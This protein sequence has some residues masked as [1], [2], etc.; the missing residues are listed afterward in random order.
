M[1]WQFSSFAPKKSAFAR[2]RRG[3]YQIAMLGLAVLMG[4][5]A[6]ALHAQ[7]QEPLSI[8]ANYFVTGDYV[9]GGVGLQ[10][11]GDSTGY[12]TGYIHIPDSTVSP[13]TGGVQPNEQHPIP[14][15]ADIVAAF[16]YWETVESP[17]FPNAGQ[18]GWF[19]GF[20]ISGTSLV[21]ASNAPVSWS[22]GG[23][24]GSA[25]GSKYVTSYRADVRP[26]LN[27]DPST[28]R[29]LGNS[30]L[31]G[32]YSVKLRDSGSNGGGIPLTLGATLV[33]IYRVL[34]PNVPL[35]SIVI[36]DGDYAP[37]NQASTMTQQIEGFYDATGGSV[38]EL[39]HIVGNGQPKKLETVE[40]NGSPQQTQSLY[41]ALPPF[42]GFYNDSW[43]NPTWTGLNV[44]NGDSVETASVTPTGTN[45]GCEVWGAVI[46]GTTVQDS[47]NDGLL[48]AWKQAKGYT[49]V[50]TGRQVLLPG[51]TSGEKDVF[52]DLDYLTNLSKPLAGAYIHS[53]LPKQA[54]IDE[55]GQ[56]FANAGVHI[57]FD[58]GNVYQ[59]V[60]PDPYI[61]TDGS[62]NAITESSLICQDSPNALCQFPNQV[63][64]GWKAGL[65]YVEDAAV[66]PN[67][68]PTV[69]YFDQAKKDSYHYVLFGHAL[70]LPL[71]WWTTFGATTNDSTVA[72][73]TSIVV[74]ANTATVT[75]QT[76]ANCAGS[77]PSTSGPCYVY[78]GE[79]I[80]PDNP[81]YGDTNL[82]RITVV[83]A[84]NFPALN[85]V[86]KFSN[87]NSSTSNKST[88]T[89]FTI[90]TSGVANGTYT[91]ANE[92]RLA[93]LFAGPSS[94]S[95][96]SD[97]GGGD[98]LITFGLWPAD[99]APGCQPIPSMALAAGQSYCDNEV[100]NIQA[101][102][103]TLMHEL[104]HSFTLTHGGTYYPPGYPLTSIAIDGQNCKPNYESIMN[105]LFQV[106]GFP[107]GSPI[108]YSRQTLPDLSEDLL[109]ESIGLGV[110]STN[111]PAMH[112][113]RWFA[114]PNSF[115]KKI[116][117]RT[118][119]V[120]CDGSPLIFGEQG[121]VA[122]DNA[123]YTGVILPGTITTPYSAPIDWN[124][125]LVT[126][127]ADASIDINL[128]GV[129]DSST[130]NPPT[131]LQGFNDWNDIDFRQIG[132]RAG[133]G[134][135]SGGVGLTGGGGV[136]L[137]GGGFRSSGG[138]A[139][140]DLGD[141]GGVGLTG[142][143]FRSSGGGV[144][145][146]GGG[147][148]STGGGEVDFDLANSTVDPPTQLSAIMGT[149]AVVLNWKSPAFSQIRS[150]LI[151]RLVGLFDPNS[152]DKTYNP[153]T[154]AKLIATVKGTPPVTTYTDT[155]IKNKT[156][157]TYFVVAALGN[158]LQSPA[159]KG[160]SIYVVF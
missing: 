154:N 17:Q 134:G 140:S 108:D 32:P 24:S 111:A 13:V 73:L 142:G 143:G 9:V 45:G 149:R 125:D 39:T 148:R 95:G 60:P 22:S 138:G 158:G 88:T 89:T 110:D 94:S 4:L 107:E 141:G 37:T 98:S 43:D 11:L 16:L 151:Y 5:T 53:H 58:V 77:T 122:V 137:T 20:P 113:T 78:P 96:H 40:F 121:E 63:A 90:T 23:C 81:A 115:D 93:V 75:L 92:P 7:A 42:P 97:V 29:V 66:S 114:P 44:G 126:A 49:D 34:S 127:D 160:S 150:Y 116:G 21:S 25:N 100:G 72:Q 133:A 112:A 64:A 59:D 118:A 50:I 70:G 35:K 128:D 67:T 109:S 144:G 47:D 27:I 136:G 6:P 117:N 41:G 85:G 87:A 8:F 57:H 155:T 124:N 31:N 1:P 52:V 12:A 80:P 68:T 129:I 152:S 82:D 2:C 139:P 132:A 46:F 146:T 131:P 79:T 55:V 105:Y 120:N 65:L 106:R 119:P 61:I 145:L 30:P 86:Y 99:D 104:G 33:I 84:I 51:A 26:D 156:T 14:A 101:Q 19:N 69:G 18:N 135:F 103:G 28:G 91:F 74:S 83:D 130:T 56:A 10:G 62:S 36:Y 157:Y 3:Q 54:A 38:A 76:P 48:D 153:L 102:A 123:G 15:G 147:F 71:S 159:S